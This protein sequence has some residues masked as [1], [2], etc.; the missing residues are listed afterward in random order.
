MRENEKDLAHNLDS[1][2][3]CTKGNSSYEKE[4]YLKGNGV[5]FL[6]LQLFFCYS[7]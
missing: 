4:D 5:L 2:L 1:F 7:F 3:S 6:P